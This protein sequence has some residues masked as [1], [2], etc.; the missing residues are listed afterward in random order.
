MTTA[1]TTMTMTMPN[2]DDNDD[3]MH[4]HVSW[5]IIVVCH[6]WLISILIIMCFR[7]QIQCWKRY[8]MHA[9]AGRMAVGCAATAAAAAATNKRQPHQTMWAR[10]V[11]G[12]LAGLPLPVRCRE[13]R[14]QCDWI[15]WLHRKSALETNKKM[16]FNWAPLYTQIRGR[17]NAK[18]NG[19]NDW[20]FGRD[21]HFD[22]LMWRDIFCFGV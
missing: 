2:D 1:T 11:G 20:N 7:Y 21:Y 10:D 17:L 6:T 15:Y 19:R 16:W 9:R 14:G 5:P 18:K 12:M 22:D 13:D 3:D 4:I 8:E